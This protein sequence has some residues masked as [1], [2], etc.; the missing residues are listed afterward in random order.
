MKTEIDIIECHSLVLEF[1]TKF[2]FKKQ[3]AEQRFAILNEELNE[4]H[5]A[6]NDIDRLDGL[7][8]SLYV[9]LGTLI[10]FEGNINDFDDNFYVVYNRFSDFM[11]AFKEVHRSNMSKSCKTLDEVHKTIAGRENLT[12]EFVDGMYFVKDENMKLI[13]S[14]DYIKANLEPYI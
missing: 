13:K 8:D 12:Y 14:V 7:V 9:E 5:N 10:N 3:T 4:F 6:T 11:G 2:R 1:H